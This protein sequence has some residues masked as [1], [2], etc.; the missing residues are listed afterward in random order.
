[1]TAPALRAVVVGAGLAGLSAAL[2][3]QRCGARVTV[4]EGRHRVGGSLAPAEGEASELESVACVLP[5]SA[6]RLSALLQELGLAGALERV[7]LGHARVAGRGGAGSRALST[8]AALRWMPLGGLRLARFQ[9]VADWLG[10]RVDPAAPELETRLDDRST[11]DLCRLYLGPRAYRRLFE[12]LLAAA[13]GLDAAETSRELLYTWL[14]P[15]A[16]PELSLAIGAGALAERLAS[17]LPELRLGARVDAVLDGGRGLRLASGEQIAADAVVLATGPRELL[18]L[19]PDLHH[20]EREF[21]ERCPL[22]AEHWLAFRADPQLR[23]PERIGWCGDGGL[24][25]FDVTPDGVG[26][27]SRW[28][29]RARGPA[30]PAEIT[31]RCDAL[32]PGLSASARGA[33]PFVRE[34][35]PD[36]GVGHFR[37]VARVLACGARRRERRIRFSGDWLVGPGAEAAIA[38]GERAALELLAAQP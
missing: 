5:R 32:V 19:V 29:A 23:L 18:R 17:H 30:A 28:L 24:A 25:L 11:G 8:R 12:P 4:L 2:R 9:A 22:H 1:V 20:V 34:G 36:F 27:A 6:P 35:A 14:G 21:L 33:R 16:D 26:D 10:A 38:S 37:A 13:F 31:A 15:G 7:P 3:L